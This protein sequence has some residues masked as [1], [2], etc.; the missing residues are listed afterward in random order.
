MI[1]FVVCFDENYN[2]VAYLFF[3]TLLNN[4]SEKINLFIIHKN[5]DTF[6]QTKKDY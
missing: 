5:P 2:D 4:V 3:H 6:E 1:N